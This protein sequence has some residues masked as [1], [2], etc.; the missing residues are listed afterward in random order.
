MWRLYIVYFV[1]LITTVK[2]P[3]CGIERYTG[4]MSIIYNYARKE[5]C[6]HVQIIEKKG[7]YGLR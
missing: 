6:R 4:K 2:T 7:E 5:Q 3:F 1:A